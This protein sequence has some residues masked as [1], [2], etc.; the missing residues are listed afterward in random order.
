LKIGKWHLGFYKYE[1]TPQHRG[2]DTFFGYYTG[3]EEY[4]NHTSPCWQCG[5]YTA[6]DLHRATAIVDT[7]VHDQSGIYSTNLFAKEAI[8]LIESHDKDTPM[9]L[10]MPFEAVHGAASCTPDC[11]APYGDLLQ[12]PQYYI[13]QQNQIQDIDRRTYAGMVGALDDAV[14]NI[15]EA[16]K[17]AGMWNNTVLLFTTDNGAPASHFDGRAMNNWPL[18]GQKGK[19]ICI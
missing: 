18:R 4:W 17:K 9:F 5:N 19:G 6:L 15:T 16:L 1:Y 14:K 11:Y 8:E 2:F 3:N 12:A 13:S 10:Y 7:P